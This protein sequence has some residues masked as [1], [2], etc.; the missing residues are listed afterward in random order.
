VF[1][2]A[3]D[4]EINGK[5]SNL[6]HSQV[7]QTG[8]REGGKEGGRERE[9]E[10]ER[11]RERGERE[12]ERREFSRLNDPLK[13]LGKYRARKSFVIVSFNAPSYKEA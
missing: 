1:A 13:E 10:T 4:N 5:Q 2:F 6:F 11:E 3:H 7:R 8:G 12:R 9:R